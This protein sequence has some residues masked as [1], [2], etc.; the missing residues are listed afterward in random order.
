MRGAR[1]RLR[2]CQE[3][4]GEVEGQLQECMRQAVCIIDN[5]DVHPYWMCE[6]CADHNVR[7]R[8]AI[9]WERKEQA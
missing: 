1:N 6:E 9:R 7:N 2:L 4:T 8:Q 5:G 3:V